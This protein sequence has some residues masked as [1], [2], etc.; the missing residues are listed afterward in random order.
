MASP[1][2]CAPCSATSISTRS[3]GWRAS[4]RSTAR[5]SHAPIEQYAAV[6]CCFVQLVF[7]AHGSP[8]SGT[9][10]CCWSW[11]SVKILTDPNFDPKLGRIL[12]RV[13]PPGIALEQA[14]RSSTP[15]C[16]RTRTRIICRSTRSSG[17]RKTFRFLRRRRWRSGSGGSAS[18]TRSIWRAGDS[19]A[20]RRRD[21]PCGDGARIAGTATGS[22]DGGA[23]RTCI[24]STPARRSSSPAT[25]RSPRTRI[26]LVERTLWN[27][28]RA[29]DL[30]L[31]P[32]GYA[33]WWKPGFRKGHLTHEDALTL[34]ERLRARTFVP[35]S[36]G[37]VPARDG[38]GARRDSTSARA[39]R[40]APP[41]RGGSHSRAGRGARA[42]RQRRRRD[43]SRRSAVALDLSDT[44]VAHATA[45]G[46]GALAVVRLSGAERHTHRSLGARPLAA[47]HAHARRC[48]SVRDAAGA[49]LDQ[50]DRASIRRAGVVHRRRRGRDHHARRLGRADD[51]R[52]RSDRARSA[53]WRDPGE[54]TRRAV[55]NGKLDIL[56]AEATGDLVSASSRAGAARGAPPT[57]RRLEPAR[58]GAARPAHRPRGADRLRHR[59]PR[60]GRRPHRAGADR[61]ARPTSSIDAL[62][63]LLATARAG[64]LVRE[65]ALV[66]LAGAPN[67]GKSSLFNALLGHNRAIVTD[68]PGT[69]R[70]AIEAVIDTPTFPL[71]LVDTAGLRDALDPVERIGVEVSESYVAR[72]SVVLA[73]ADSAASR[74]RAASPSSAARRR[75][76]SFS[77]GRKPMCARRRPTESWRPSESRS[78]PSTAVAV[79]AESGEGLDALLEAIGARGAAR[80]GGSPRQR[81]ADAD[82]RATPLRRVARA[83]RSAGVSRAMDDG[84]VPAPVAAVHLREAVASLEDLVGASRRRGRSGRSL[85]ALLRRE[86]RCDS[87]RQT[88]RSGSSSARTLLRRHRR[89]LAERRDFGRAGSHGPRQSVR[90][91]GRFA[92]ARAEVV[93]GALRE[94]VAVDRSAPRR[95]CRPTDSAAANPRPDRS[96]SLATRARHHGL[97]LA[98]VGVLAA[99]VAEVLPRRVAGTD[100]ARDVDGESLVD[101]QLSQ[102]RA[103]AG[104]P[105]RVVAADSATMSRSSLRLVGD[106]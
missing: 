13:S 28:A 26:D 33:P 103:A 106:V 84:D 79:S 98:H 36:L 25:R 86:V 21:D 23:R 16:S 97:E 85:S 14:A 41:A 35:V 49:E 93:A 89:R 53:A 29:L 55:L 6:A 72:A 81:R 15:F 43:M 37:N 42:R 20:R 75:R 34:F 65:G 66:V 95:S 101:Q 2:T 64:E 22:I 61:D 24:C 74:S 39:A 73:C 10:R 50:A 38:D 71:R 8:T 105:V 92:H 87:A 1:R 100:G 68:I 44:I 7:C 76:R 77:C 80:C 78:A 90:G 56:Q 4:S 5:R 82:P 58:S 88:F 57:R 18:R 32:I 31:L 19:V 48:A 54:F 99:L 63:H 12:P 96:R 27:R 52:G 69:T 94:H 46:R 102:R 3:A 83:R 9:R 40:G 17:C 62:E 51:R 104:V 47:T 60:R 67:V 11:A 70:D 30:A 91:N 45:P 59:F